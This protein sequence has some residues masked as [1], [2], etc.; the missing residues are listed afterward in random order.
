MGPDFGTFEFIRPAFAQSRGLR[1]AGVAMRLLTPFPR[2][3]LRDRLA[4]A[5]V[6]LV[7]NQAHH[8]GRGHL[9]LDVVDALSDLDHPPRV[10][11]AFA[12]LGGANVS[13]DTWEAMLDHARLAL[14]GHALPAHA[15]FHE[16]TRS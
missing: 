7:V 11:G 5:K 10:V 4:A 16:G 1:V 15:L 12:G 8:H 3:A 2:A 14:N 13:E 9:T 6:V